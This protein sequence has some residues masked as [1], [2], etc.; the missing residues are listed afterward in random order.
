MTRMILAV[1]CVFVLP[2]LIV[3]LNFLGLLPA[4]TI[5]ERWRVS[6]IAIVVFSGLVTPA[7]DVLSMFVVAGAMTALFFAAWVVA[8]VHDRRIARREHAPLTSSR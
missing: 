7:A 3:V 1:G 5:L 2:V 8:A 4:R 6:V